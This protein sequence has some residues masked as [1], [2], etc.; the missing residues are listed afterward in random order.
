MQRIEDALRGITQP[1]TVQVHSV[2]RG[3]LV[4][5]TK[6]VFIESTPPILVLHIKRFL[7]NAG[8]VQKS[9]KVVGYGTT[10]DIQNG[11]PHFVL[12]VEL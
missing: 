1:E 10:L 12:F 9:P 7:Y 11:E 5:A 8:G 2:S 6:Q 3:G 4:D